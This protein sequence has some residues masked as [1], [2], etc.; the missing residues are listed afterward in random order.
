[1]ANLFPNIE[2]DVCQ[3]SW[4]G[5]E[6]FVQAADGSP[7][8]NVP[9]PYL[10]ARFHLEWSSTLSIADR[11]TLVA[12][13]KSYRASLFTFFDFNTKQGFD[14]VTIGT[15]NGATTT[16]T[17]PA[18]TTSGRTIKKA[19]VVQVEG[20]AYT[21][22]VG[23]GAE[24]EDRITFAVA[25]TLGQIV[26]AS[27]TSGQPRHSAYYTPGQIVDEI[28]VEAD[29]WQLKLEIEEKVPPS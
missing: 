1:M 18:K 28:H 14:E 23:T 4:K 24:G 19:T 13:W 2:P 26:T 9:H 21:V 22:G 17:L 15:G 11:K 16:F 20:V 5:F 10:Q 7:Q 29:V 25:P 6:T 27:A 12:H 8:F 3:R